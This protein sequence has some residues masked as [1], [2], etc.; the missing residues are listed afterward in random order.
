[1]YYSTRASQQEGLGFDSN[2]SWWRGLSVSSLHVHPQCYPTFVH[3]VLQLSINIILTLKNP[4]SLTHPSPWQQTPSSDKAVKALQSST[5]SPHKT[6]T[7]VLKSNSVINNSFLLFS[8]YC[9][10]Y[11]ISREYIKTSVTHKSW[12]EELWFSIR[13]SPRQ[14]D[15]IVSAVFTCS[16]SPHSLPLSLL[17]CR[18]ITH[19]WGLF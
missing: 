17:L 2:T 4:F 5:P 15:L 7:A 3:V 9:R 12:E 16:P 10:F 18:T 6:A 13:A 14:S 19:R 8:L 1:M 11:A